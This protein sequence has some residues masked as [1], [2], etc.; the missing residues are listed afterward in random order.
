MALECECVCVCVF[1]CVCDCYLPSRSRWDTR[2]VLGWM[3]IRVAG[4]NCYLPLGGQCIGYV[5]FAS[6]LL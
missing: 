4:T 3:K 2:R 6:M 1:V 5:G